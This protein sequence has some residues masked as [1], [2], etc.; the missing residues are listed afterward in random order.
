VLWL[1]RLPDHCQDIATQGIE[2][3]LIP[4]LRGELFKRF[5]GIVLSAVETL[6]YEFLHAVAQRIEQNGDHQ[7]GGNDNELRLLF[8]TGD[9]TESNLG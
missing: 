5:G 4:Q 2:V 8:L 9:D 3:C 7:G 6:V 1:H